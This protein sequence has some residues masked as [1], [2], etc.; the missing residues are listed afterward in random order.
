MPGR[1]GPCGEALI[2]RRCKRSA[3]ALRLWLNTLK[4]DTGSN[5]IG[6]LP[7]RNQMPRSTRRGPPI[8]SVNAPRSAAA[9]AH[10]LRPL[11]VLALGLQRRRHHHLG[12]L[13]LLDGGVA[14]G[15]HR[16]RQGAEEVEGAVV[17]QR[18]AAQDLAQRAD[19]VHPYART[20]LLYT[21][22]SPR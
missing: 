17:L 5:V 12:T 14:G 10:A 16:G 18:R 11:V 9:H 19:G 21:S 15:R 13:E 4:R 3:Y 20:C 6:P 7:H 8:A 2:E 1:Q 22:P